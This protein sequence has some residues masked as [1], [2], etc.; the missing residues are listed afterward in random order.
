MFGGDYKE[1]LRKQREE[2]RLERKQKLK[3]FNTQEKEPIGTIFK[4]QETKQDFDSSKIG[5]IISICM[6][7]IVFVIAYIIL[8]NMVLLFK[9]PTS[10]LFYA[11]IVITVIGNNFLNLLVTEE[12]KEVAGVL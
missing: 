10:Q 4:K 9:N 11:I 1:K 3:S 8:L 12:K 2:K 6:Q 5:I 7:I